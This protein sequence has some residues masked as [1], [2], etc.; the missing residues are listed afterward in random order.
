[1]EHLKKSPSPLI[2][3]PGKSGTVIRG[4]SLLFALPIYLF[5]FIWVPVVLI[6][7]WM[8][9]LPYRLFK[10]LKARLTMKSSGS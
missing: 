1:M 5:M 2:R 10:F 8:A 4:L 9:L 6:F 3:S 7:V